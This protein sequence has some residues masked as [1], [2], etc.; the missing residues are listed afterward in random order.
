MNVRAAAPLL[1]APQNVFCPTN[2][3]AGGMS[4]VQQKPFPPDIASY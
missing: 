4:A 3:D 2:S 1:S